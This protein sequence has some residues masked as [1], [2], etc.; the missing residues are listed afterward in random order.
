MVTLE[1]DEPRSEL[2][3]SLTF[4]RMAQ[5]ESVLK[6]EKRAYAEDIDTLLDAWLA[7]PAA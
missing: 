2:E 5:P 6:S 1:G 3:E 7:T 4:F